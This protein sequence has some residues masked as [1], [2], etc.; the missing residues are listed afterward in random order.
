MHF[1]QKYFGGSSMVSQKM[2]TC[3]KSQNPNKKKMKKCFMSWWNYKS[4]FIKITQR[5][6]CGE[7]NNEQ[8]IT[9]SATQSV[10]N[11]GDLAIAWV[12]VA[13]RGNNK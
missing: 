2:H 6:S 1:E 8:L 4:N 10:K 3:G 13:A 9:Q 7:K 5:G 12:C 11:S